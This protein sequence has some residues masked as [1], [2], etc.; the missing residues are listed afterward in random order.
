MEVGEDGLDQKF[1]QTLAAVFVEDKDVGKVSEGGLIGD[2][3]GV[4]G[5]RAGRSEDSEVE[6]ICE[7]GGEGL[8]AGAAR[9]VGRSMREASEVTW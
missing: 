2:D 6:R 5:E 4:G 1:R 3:A 7:R 8:R 9:S